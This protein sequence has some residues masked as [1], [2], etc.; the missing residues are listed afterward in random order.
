MDIPL[1]VVLYDVVTTADPPRLV[2]TCRN[3][4]AQQQ[5]ATRLNKMRTDEELHGGEEFACAAPRTEVVQVPLVPGS[6][7]TSSGYDVSVEAVAQILVK[8]GGGG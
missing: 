8:A 6:R 4:G 3:A 7:V 1:P 2:A 5:L